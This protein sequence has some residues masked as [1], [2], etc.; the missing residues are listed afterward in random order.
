VQ[1]RVALAELLGTHPQ[2]RAVTCGHVHLAA[3]GRLGSTPVLAS[4][5]TWRRHF[6][7]DLG[8]PGLHPVMGPA[9]FVVHVLVDGELVSHVRMLDPS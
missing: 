1:D 6:R 4:P 2:V 7:L 9:G 3:Q 5:S 8:E